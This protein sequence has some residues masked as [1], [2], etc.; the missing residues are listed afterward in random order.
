MDAPLNETLKEVEEALK[1][2]KELLMNSNS[3]NGA[4]KPIESV[5]ATM[6][7]GEIV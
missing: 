4:W 6:K 7:K 1:V 3:Q 2:A 5:L